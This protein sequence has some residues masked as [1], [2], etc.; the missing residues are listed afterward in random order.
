[1]WL[2]S[3]SSEYIF[4]LRRNQAFTTWCKNGTNLC[5]TEFSFTEKKKGET[6]FHIENEILLS[7]EK[8]FKSNCKYSLYQDHASKW[9]ANIYVSASKTSYHHRLHR[10]KLPIFVCKHHL[11]KMENVTSHVEEII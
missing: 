4:G 8:Q 11:E 1:M 7:F 5:C 2:V 9:L 3:R 10:R 6:V